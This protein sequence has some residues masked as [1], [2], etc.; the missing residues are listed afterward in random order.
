MGAYEFLGKGVYTSLGHKG[1][2]QYKLD[3]S[4]GISIM[5][6]DNVRLCYYL[7]FLDSVFLF[8]VLKVDDV[9]NKVEE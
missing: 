8:P 6:F 1:E 9:R 4:I 2:V 3:C 5:V 7:R